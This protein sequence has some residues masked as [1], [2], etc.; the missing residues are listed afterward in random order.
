MGGSGFSLRH[1]SGH[2]YHRVDEPVPDG[3]LIGRTFGP[4]PDTQFFHPYIDEDDWWDSPVHLRH[5]HGGFRDNDTKF[6]SYFPATAGFEGRFFQYVMPA[7]GSERALEGAAGQEDKIGFSVRSG[8]YFVE[9]NGGGDGSGRPDS[10]MDP[11]YAGYRAVAA[12][13]Q[14]SRVVAA[15]LFPEWDRHIYGHLFGVSG[16]A[17]RTIAAAEHT[18]GVWDG[19]V[20]GVPGSPMA[21]PNVF[22]VRM[23]A[24]RVLAPKLD[25]IVDALEPGGSGNP[26][27]G[28]DG[29]EAAVLREVTRM[30]MPPRTW[31]G[32]KTMGTQAFASVYGPAKAV[33]SVFLADFWTKPGYEGAD[34][35]SGFAA[36]RRAYLVTVKKPLTRAEAVERGLIAVRRKEEVA[37]ADHAFQRQD[38]EGGN[39]VGFTVSSITRLGFSDG[40]LDET[41]RTP[42][43]LFEH[44][45]L[46]GDLSVRDGAHK[47]ES[48]FAEKAVDDV[49]LYSDQI[50][51]DLPL[52]PGTTVLLDNSGYLAM[53]TYH[54]HQMPDRK[55]GF[56]SWDQFR[57]ADGSPAF[58]QRQMLMGPLFVRATGCEES[59]VTH[60]KMI[61]IASLLDREAFPWQAD[62]YAH[63]LRARFGDAYDDNARLWYTDNALH[64]DDE[65]QEDP[66]HTVS[67]LGVQ[68]EALL[69]LADWVEHDIAPAASTAHGVLGGQVVVPD[70][71]EE[72]HGIQPTVRLLADGADRADVRTGQSVTLRVLASSPDDAPKIDQ[73]DWETDGSHEFGQ[74]SAVLPT[75]RLDRSR[76]VTFDRPGTYHV[77]VRVSSQ[78]KGY[79]GTR[80]CRLYNV[81][82]ARVVVSD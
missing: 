12:C 50:D 41:Q 71:A 18:D 54:R 29:R 13:A 70:R 36:A 21:I 51:H 61:L 11:T 53:Q 45:D 30:G 39:I 52:E 19:F 73:I 66:T 43:A 25:S 3:G 24:Q 68:Q 22:A 16:G 62:W 5:V 77:A 7:P 6:S 46:G 79:E 8:G 55:D 35:D 59:G 23:L 63:R 60:G 78:R 64:A 31:F 20:P 57:T 56:A 2:R 49:V 4:L 67:Y 38:V 76:T 69:Q 40:V 14:F 17:Y 37:G 44:F 34:P 72:R 81:A 28:L 74:S 10:P 48:T 32:W 42:D 65:P 47:G 58:P 82:R 9:T 33:D 26:Y 15:L 1:R 80:L 27:A 75:A